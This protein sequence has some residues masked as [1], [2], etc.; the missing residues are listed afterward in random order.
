MLWATLHEDINQ[1][2]RYRFT[3]N[4]TEL[5]Q[6]FLREERKLFLVFP[7]CKPTS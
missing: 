6:S 3:N 4:K 7:R 1:V 5:P 2:S